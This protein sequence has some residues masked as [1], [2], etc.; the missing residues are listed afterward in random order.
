MTSPEVHPEG[1]IVQ[2]EGATEA[3]NLGIDLPDDHEQAIALLLSKLEESR[4][5][6]TSY[7]DD[8]KRVAADFD[9]YRKRTSRE[10]GAL[11]DRAA[12]RVVS[13][14]MP[15]LDSF[16]AAVATEPVTDSERQ[17]FAGML[18]T[19][20]QLL[21]ALE[22]EGLEVIPSIGEPF[23]PEVHEP[24]GAPAGNG[25]LT[26]ATELRRGYMLR[27]RLLRAA[28]VVLESSE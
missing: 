19:R 7:L 9:N 25:R 28:L 8:L 24:A 5:E 14:L 6:A 17:L 18:G 10:Q 15:V 27:G 23:D 21:K 20:E 4:N 11:V 3:L 26:V 1:E 2:T 22:A 13:E 12:E 16:D